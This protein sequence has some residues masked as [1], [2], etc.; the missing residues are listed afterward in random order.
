MQLRIGF[1][2][3]LL[4][5]ALAAPVAVGSANANETCSFPVTMTDA[6]GT[7]VTVEEEPE[8]VVTLN[9]SAAQTMWEIGAREKVVGLSK[10]AL[11]LNGAEERTQISGEEQIVVTERV[12]DLE[13][14]LVL[15]PNTIPNETVEQ[16]R[17]AGLTVYHFPMEES[18]E[19]VY[20]STRIIGQL[21][22]E[23]EGAE[24][25]VAW[26]Q[27]RI[28]VVQ[29]AVEGQ[30]RPDVLYLF[31]GYTA[32]QG[33]FINE[34]IETAGGNNIAAEVGIEYYQQISEEV[35]VEQDPDW[36]VLNSNDPALP[37]SDAYN[38][39]TAVQEGNVVVVQ[40]EHLNQPAPRIVYAITKLAEHF[41]PEAYAAANATPTATM[42]ATATPESTP[43]V[44]PSATVATTP[45]ESDG[46]P[47]FGLGAALGAIA[48]ALVLARARR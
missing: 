43:M 28:G 6:S 46:Q 20:E 13:P 22:G 21:T 45:T 16:L 14:D 34:V 8:R 4:I 41:H 3:V 9:P 38:Q 19:D 32:G 18:I 37:E 11:Y 39:T 10:Y 2:S 17:D 40:I 24:E 35:V 26:M 12:V 7:E 27:D 31:F 23:C 30:D 36:I 1:V 47:G 29:E 42:T 5:I 15:A 25:T 48:A 44:T 33:T